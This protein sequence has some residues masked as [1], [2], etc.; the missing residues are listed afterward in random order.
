VR[1]PMLAIAQYEKMNHLPPNYINCII[2]NLGPNGAFQRFERGEIAL[3]PFYEAFSL[4]LSA[5]EGKA[6]YE[7]YCQRKG[8]KYPSLPHDIR[9]NGR[10][11]FGRM[12][13]ESAI[14][15]GLVVEA[16]KRLRATGKYRIIALTNN[17]SKSEE[18]I[19]V[20]APPGHDIRKELEFLGWQEGA[21]T[22]ELRELFDDFCDSSTYGL[23]KPDPAFYLL[24][25]KRNNIEPSEA[26]FLDDIGYNLKAARELGIKTIQVNIGKSAQALEELGQLLGL[27][28]T[29]TSDVP[30]IKAQ[31]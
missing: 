15:D 8:L 31:L 12:M 22:S 21:V 9:V 28:L 24:A 5:P 20:G 27:D 2:A 26:V 10:E 1:S 18:T 14:F 23:R 6:W 4:E 7:Q 19:A 16:I 11:L 3:F 29:G 25:C 30:H 17:F 13:R